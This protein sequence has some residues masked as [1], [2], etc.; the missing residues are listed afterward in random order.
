MRHQNVNVMK[1]LK[2]EF[3]VAFLSNR[4]LPS[5]DFSFASFI[6]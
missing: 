1:N 4:N 3:Q 5:V 2:K 6:C